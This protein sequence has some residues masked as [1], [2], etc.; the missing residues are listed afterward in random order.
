[1]TNR[2]DPFSTTAYDS[3]YDELAAPQATVL[4]H[5]SSYELPQFSANAPIRCAYRAIYIAPRTTTF[6]LINTECE[7]TIGS[8]AVEFMH[9]EMQFYR[10][11]LV[12]DDGGW[13]PPWLPLRT[14]CSVHLQSATLFAAVLMCQ[15]TTLYAEV[16]MHQST[17]LYA[18]VLMPPK[19]YEPCCGVYTLM[20]Y[21]YAAV[22]TP[23]L[24]EIRTEVSTELAPKYCGRRCLTAPKDAEVVTITEA[25]LLRSP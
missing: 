6:Y 4:H 3:D 24:Y 16:L 17:T 20:L 7:S 14:R 18:T 10:P 13:E 9:S 5:T 8:Y 1:M 21:R 12:D 19:R 22:T 15:S 25:G 2:I 23:K 11:H